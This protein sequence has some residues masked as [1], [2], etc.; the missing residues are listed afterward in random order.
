MNYFALPEGYTLG[1]DGMA[2]DEYG[3]PFAPAWPE[4]QAVR[5]RRGVGRELAGGKLV[6]R[7]PI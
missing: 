2:Y 7:I 5:P 6:R 4:E 1:E 3:R